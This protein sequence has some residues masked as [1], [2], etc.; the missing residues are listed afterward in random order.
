[1]GVHRLDRT[2]ARRIAIRAQ[3]LD[4]ARPTD[5]LAVVNQLTFL[6]VDPTAVIAPNADLVAWTRLGSAYQPVHLTSALESDRSLFELNALIRPITDLGLY[7]AEMATWPTRDYNRKWLTSNDRFVGDILERLAAS[8][9]LLSRDIPD[10]SQVPWSSSGW[11]GDRNV[12]QMLEFLMMQGKVAIV[13]RQGRQRVWD[14][15]E[16]VY[17]VDVSVIA[18]D[19]AVRMRNDR[20]LRALGIARAMGT[21]TP[22]EPA[23]VGE[24]GEPATV[25]GV[26]GEWRVDPEAIGKPFEGRTAILS[27]FD[28]LTHDR[29]RALELFDFE[30]TLEMYKPKEQRR[31]GYFALPVLHHDQLVGKVDATG[32]RKT[33]T[34]QVHAI[35]QDV[36]FTKRIRTDVHA[37]LESLAAWIGLGSVHLP[38]STP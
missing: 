9:P 20:R 37:E 34:L 1:M 21:A 13:G 19:D 17:P 23:F 29:G 10:T 8:G 5:L 25:D 38:P 3:M 18:A 27:P 16:R 4:A 24:A 11:T 7:R 22:I 36:P 26:H 14:L 6:Q 2:E 30:Y 32:D 12:T 15:A 33:S 35:H 28:R 31:W